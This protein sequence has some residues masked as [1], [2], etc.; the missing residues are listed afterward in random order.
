MSQGGSPG[1]APRVEAT[2]GISFLVAALVVCGWDIVN[3][4]LGKGIDGDVSQALAGYSVQILVAVPGTVGLV[5]MGV[6]L[7]AR[8]IERLPGRRRVHR[9]IIIL[10]ASLPLLILIPSMFSGPSISQSPLRFPLMGAVVLAVVVAAHTLAKMTQVLERSASS[11][12][13]VGLF[14]GVLLAAGVVSA[15]GLRLVSQNVLPGLY[16]PFHRALTLLS[17]AVLA[18]AF[19]V[20]LATSSRRVGTGRTLIFLS[21]AVLIGWPVGSV[22]AATAPVARQLLVEEGVFVGPFIGPIFVAETRLVS[23]VSGD[24]QGLEEAGVT[25][26]FAGVEFAG[27]RKKSVVLVTVDALR[28]DVLLPDSRY[29]KRAGGLNGISR[30]ALVFERAYS[31]SN[32]T[33]ISVPFLVLGF[34]PPAGRTPSVGSCLSAPFNGAGYRTEFFFTAH[35]YAS[36]EK[37]DLWPLA[38]RGFFFQFYHPDYRSAEEVLARVERSLAQA[39]GPVFIWAHL[40]DVHFPFLLHGQKGSS[41]GD[42]EKSYAG[43][44]EYLDSVLAPFFQRLIERD[45]Q[46]IWALS[47]DHGE[48]YGEHNN[49]YHGSS[50]YE[51]QVRVPLLLGGPGVEQGSVEYPVS[52]THLGA[53]LLELAGADVGEAH[54]LPLGPPGDEAPVPDVHLVGKTR[55]GIVRGDFKLVADPRNGT[56]GLFNLRDDPGE[57]DNLVERRADLAGELLTEIRASGCRHSTAGMER[58]LER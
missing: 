6:A 37:T 8:V 33:P 40:S 14:A 5:A 11:F 28:G 20:A 34:D 21:L 44:V 10:V 54:V 39:D 9:G 4:A 57:S 29:G 24:N 55:C 7:L 41:S 26:P 42:Y 19:Y 53:T 31:P 30:R 58:M 1:A 50:L 47:S 15:L 27:D 16:M 22:L 17:V 46:V 35:G 32:Y 51:E 56:L 45:D 48:A 2:I 52:I 18:A 13:R 23:L 49:V 38:S 12:K 43:Q 3:L 36:L 25:P